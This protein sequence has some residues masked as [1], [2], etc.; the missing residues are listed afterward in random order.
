MLIATPRV[1]QVTAMFVA[2]YYCLR[3][4]AIFA[5][6]PLPLSPDVDFAYA[7]AICCH[8]AITILLRAT[9]RH[10]FASH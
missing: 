4:K 3:D 2:A 7:D 6:T 5:A 1:T 8:A 10:I 9:P